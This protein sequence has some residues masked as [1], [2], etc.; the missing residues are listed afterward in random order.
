MMP[1]DN[2][3]L[4]F[5]TANSVNKWK[6]SMLL[7]VIYCHIFHLCRYLSTKHGNSS[8]YIP[9]IAHSPN[10]FRLSGYQK[11]KH[12]KL[13]THCVWIIFNH[14]EW[15][16]NRKMVLTEKQINRKPFLRADCRL[17]GC[18]WIGADRSGTVRTWGKLSECL[19]V[20]GLSQRKLGMEMYTAWY[21]G[22]KQ[23]VDWRSLQRG[24]A[25]SNP[26]E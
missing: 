19:I 20:H 3:Y 6:L 15:K 14:L 2:L 5:W 11:G 7:T 24:I 12:G 9:Y 21:H 13:S 25:D 23:T 18:K 26:K 22:K 10:F 8:P 16:V 17:A 4:L 1:A